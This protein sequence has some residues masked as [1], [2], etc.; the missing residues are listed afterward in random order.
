MVFNTDQEVFE[1][2][3][4]YTRLL[5]TVLSRIPTTA[6]TR[7]IFVFGIKY[8]AQRFADLLINVTNLRLKES[9]VPWDSLDDLLIGPS[10]PA[11]IEVVFRVR[12]SFPQFEAN[13]YVESRLPK[14]KE[15]RLLHTDICSYVRSQYQREDWQHCIYYQPRQNIWLSIHMRRLWDIYIPVLLRILWI[16]WLTRQC[17]ISE[18]LY[19]SAIVDFVLGVKWDAGG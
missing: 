17:W 7:I 12:D 15:R 9:G 16:S 3:H 10:F 6:L 13:K 1:D 14:S 2:L 18:C 11:L 8:F 19:K 4:F 5:P